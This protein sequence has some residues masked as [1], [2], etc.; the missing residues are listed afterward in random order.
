MQPAP[1]ARAYGALRQRRFNMV[2]ESAVSS[3]GR[4]LPQATSAVPEWLRRLLEAL[5]APLPPDYRVSP[6]PHTSS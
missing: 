6:V 4:P 1:A 2:L 3:R 5:P